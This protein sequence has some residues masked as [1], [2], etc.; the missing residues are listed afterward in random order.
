LS[1]VGKWVGYALRQCGVACADVAIGIINNARS[2]NGNTSCDFIT[3]VNFAEIGRVGAN[4]GRLDARLSLILGIT[5]GDVCAHIRSDTGEVGVRAC[6]FCGELGGV[7][8]VV[9]AS[10]LIVAKVIER[11]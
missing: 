6:L 7:A 1:P 8:N 11:V 10:V 3:L 4:D 5:S 2:R 9:G